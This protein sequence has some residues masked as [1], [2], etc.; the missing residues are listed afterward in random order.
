[1]INKDLI[2]AITTSV[3]SIFVHLSHWTKDVISLKALVSYALDSMAKKIWRRVALN[4][5][6]NI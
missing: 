2:I 3:V 1:M 4:I 5:L 6:L